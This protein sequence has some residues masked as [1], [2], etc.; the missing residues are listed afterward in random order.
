VKDQYTFD[1]APYVLGALSPD[2]RRTFEEHL[3]GCPSCTAEVE[4]LSELPALLA[5]LPAD[6]PALTLPDEQL[7]PPAALLPALLLDLRR[8]RRRRRWRAGLAAGL[9]AAC[10]AGLGTA[11]VLQRG[12]TAPPTSPPAALPAA[13]PFQPISD[14]SVRAT[15]TL[16]GKAWGTEIRVWCKY[17]GEAWAK[18]HDYTL[19]AYDRA[20]ERYS[21]GSWSVIPDRDENL[22]TATAV[23]RNQLMRLQIVDTKNNPVLDLRL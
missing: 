4:E 18:P 21:I 16:V 12:T 9:A 10:L 20:G 2:E 3:R 6:D 22:T 14:D 5:Q 19:V 17:T 1:A 8:D 23:S 13:L 11:V 7:E 15:A